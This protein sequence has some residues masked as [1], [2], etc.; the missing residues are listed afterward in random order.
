MSVDASAVAR[1]VGITTAFKKFN[2]GSLVN[3]PQHI[4][5]VGQ[6]N[7]ASTYPLTKQRVSSAL[8]VGQTYGF[9]S[10]LHLAALELLPANGD[11][12]GTVPL[13]ILPLEDDGSGVAATGDIAPLG[14]ATKVAEYVAII[15]GVRSQTFV[16]N[17]GDTPTEVVAAL[18]AAV[19]GTLSIPVVAVDNAST[20]SDF[21]AKWQGVSGNDISIEIEGD[22][23]AGITFTIVD[24]AS[25]AANP[26]VT[27]A[28]DMIGDDTWITMIVNCLNLS[29]AT[30]LAAYETFG[31]GR[32]GTLVKKPLIT[33]SGNPADSVSAAISIPES[34]KTDRINVAIPAPGSNELP[35]VV[36][37]RAVSRMAPLANNNP[38]HDYGSQNLKGVNPGADTAQWNYTQRNEAVNGGSS[39]T[40]V[41]DGVINMSD[42]VTFYHPTGDETPA[43]RYV[44]DIVRLQ[45]IIFNLDLLFNTPEWDGAP[46]IP[47]DQPTNNPSAKKPKTAKAL[48][49]TLVDNLALA[50]LISDAPTAKESITSVINGSNPKRLDISLAVQLSGNTNIISIDL[51]FGFFF[52]TAPIVGA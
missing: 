19:N 41:K 10:P 34:R 28:L 47:D 20:S 3:L 36:A 44:V 12:L 14:T 43:Y 16:V 37:A 23:T 11:G 18:T 13:S 26:D 40:L 32:W 46:L 9:G 42:T 8:E 27:D 25:G 1:V 33:V 31:E 35:F 51:G 52:G 24:M 6:G 48:V 39:T 49:A 17:I 21:T 2:A 15:G 22:M 29:D 38:P 50:A 30:A 4:G 7:T 45:N 5:L